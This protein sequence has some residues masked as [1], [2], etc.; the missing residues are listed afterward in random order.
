MPKLG[1]WRLEDEFGAAAANIMAKHSMDPGVMENTVQCDAARK[2]ES[3]FVDLYQASVLN[4]RS[5]NCARAHTHRQV[6]AL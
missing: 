5:P 1:P 6:R 3:A 4:S 2:T